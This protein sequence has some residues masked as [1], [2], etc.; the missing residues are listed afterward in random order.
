[1][2]IREASRLN[3]MEHELDDL[4]YR[5]SALKADF[6]DLESRLQDMDADFY[7]ENMEDA[8]DFYSD[9]VDLKYIEEQCRLPQ[10]EERM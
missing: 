8:S 7:G 5:L 6:R 3:G 10:R 1:M 9:I 4:E 2:T